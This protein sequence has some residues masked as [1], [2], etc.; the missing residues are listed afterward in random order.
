MG[1]KGGG[2]VRLTTLPPSVS[3]LSRRRGCL[4]LS[5]PYGPSRPVNLY[6]I[7][8]SICLLQIICGTSELEY[9]SGLRQISARY[10]FHYMTAILP[11]FFL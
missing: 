1:V 9:R 11:R 4:D 6:M 5:H 2:R 8:T 7:V 3:R 10:V